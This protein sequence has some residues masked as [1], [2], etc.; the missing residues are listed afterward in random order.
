MCMSVL[1]LHIF[2]IQKEDILKSQMYEYSYI[3]TGQRIS[4][5]RTCGGSLS[6]AVPVKKINRTDART[7]YV[8]DIL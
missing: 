8:V 4:I 5:L 3:N 7:V 6:R 1:G 2:L